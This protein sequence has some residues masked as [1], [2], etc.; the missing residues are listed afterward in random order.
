MREEDAR[1]VRRAKAGDPDAFAD[2]Y[3]RYYPKVY[4]YLIYR[5]SDTETAED[6]SSEVFVR[7]VE[8]IDGFRYEGRPVLTWLYTVARNL[9]TDHYRRVGRTTQVPL[10]EGRVAAVDGLPSAEQVLGEERLAAAMQM[11]TDDQRQVILLRF[12]EGF[13]SAET[14]AVVGKTVGAVKA[15]QHRALANLSH[16]LAPQDVEPA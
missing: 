12:F 14:A 13:D 5:V 6:L 2:L 3:T 15:L 7:L 16:I 8:H 4:R 10:D 9:L 1:L 11:L